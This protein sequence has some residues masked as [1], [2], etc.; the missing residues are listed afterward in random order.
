MKTMCLFSKFPA[1][2]GFMVRMARYVFVFALIFS[3]LASGV[4]NGLTRFFNMPSLAAAAEKTFVEKFASPD[5]GVRPK[6]RYWWPNAEVDLDQIRLEMNQIADA[7]FNLVWTDYAFGGGPATERKTRDE[8]KDK[9]QTLGAKVS[10]SVSKKTDY[11]VVGA[12]PGS[13]AAKAEALG[14][15]M[16]DEAA[17]ARLLKKNS[18]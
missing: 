13:K 17:F 18:S 7:G 1:R 11:V 15:T 8:A 4:N 6:F 10:G 3:F 9:L 16:L 2:S 12:E 5:A 14:V